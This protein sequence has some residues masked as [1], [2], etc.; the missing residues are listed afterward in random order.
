MNNDFLKA[1]PGM[2]IHRLALL[3]LRER[4][5][6]DL[7][8][9]VSEPGDYKSHLGIPGSAFLGMYASRGIH[10][11]LTGLSDSRPARIIRS[12]RSRA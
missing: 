11:V 7:D 10:S 9:S 1:S 3:D 5:Y 4:G 12:L 8:L 6:T 2:V